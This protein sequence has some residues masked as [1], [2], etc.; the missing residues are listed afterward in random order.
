[1]DEVDI[2]ADRGDTAQLDGCLRVPAP[3]HSQES[4]K[5]GRRELLPGGKR[6]S[7]KKAI[8]RYRQQV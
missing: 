8:I 4:Q 3:D 5:Y 7:K 1:M 2:S 6:R